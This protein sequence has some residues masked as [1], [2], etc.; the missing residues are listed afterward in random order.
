MIASKSNPIYKLKYWIYQ[1]QLSTTIKISLLTVNGTC[2]TEF[3]RYIGI[4][5]L[6]RNLLESRIVTYYQAM[7]VNDGKYHR[8]RE[9]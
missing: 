1:N 9:V 5:Q 4:T 3:R 8:G 2:D 7:A 6:L